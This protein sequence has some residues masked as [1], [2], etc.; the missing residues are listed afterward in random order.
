MRRRED[1]ALELN[2]NGYPDKLIS[3]EGEE[4]EAERIHSGVIFFQKKKLD[5]ACRCDCYNALKERSDNNLQII[6]SDH[7]SEENKTAAKAV[8]LKD[9]ERLGNLYWTAGYIFAANVLLKVAVYYDKKGQDYH[10]V[11]HAY[12]TEAASKYARA[13]LLLDEEQ[14]I[15]IRQIVYKSDNFSACGFTSIAAADAIFFK[16]FDKDKVNII[17]N[18]ERK[19]LSEMLAKNKHRPQ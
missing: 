16:P 17:D 4:I 1:L 14:S 7:I 2:K 12:F 9:L 3:I 8:L 11:A 10:D 19:K 13:K 6:T 18:E 5:L 15:K